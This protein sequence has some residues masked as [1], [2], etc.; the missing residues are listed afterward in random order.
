MVAHYVRA[1][2]C[3]D[4]HQGAKCTRETIFPKRALSEFYLTDFGH[5]IWAASTSIRRRNLE[6]IRSQLSPSIY[7]SLSGGSI[8]F[9]NTQSGSLRWT[10]SPLLQPS[11]TSTPTRQPKTCPKSIRPTHVLAFDSGWS[12]QPLQTQWKCLL[13]ILEHDLL[14]PGFGL[15]NQPGHSTGWIICL[16]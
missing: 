7:L 15:H 13:Q 2:I 3:S 14:G 4:T 12:V 11:K 16:S 5:L 8:N 10:D 1:C 9:T 6:V